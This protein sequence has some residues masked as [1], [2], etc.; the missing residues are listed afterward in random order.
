MKTRRASK[1]AEVVAAVRAAH[2]LYDTPIIFRDPYAI[3][4][5]SRTWRILA[6]HR[7]AYRF[8]AE[9]LLKVLRP[10][11]GQI[12]GRARYCDEL[13]DAAMQHGMKQCVIVGAG[14]DS[15]A[16]RRRDL[17]DI[18]SI[19]E[20]DHPASQAV[21]RQRL[22]SVAEQPPQNLV[23]VPVD[24]EHSTV[25]QALRSTSFQMQEPAFFSWL[26]TTLYLSADAI[27]ATLGDIAAHAAA[28]SELLL[29]YSLSDHLL[30]GTDRAELDA[31]K[32]FVARRGEPF[33]ANFS[34]DEL[35]AK[36]TALG[37]RVIGNLSYQDQWARYFANRHDDLRPAAFSNFL[38]LAVT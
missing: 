25:M 9:R 31:L 30:T 16:L 20:L 26:G 27:F 18:L 33:R 8:V 23:F 13:L 6:R 32:K 29:D 2:L 5:T 7:L 28:G 15:L 38:H 22:V 21:K 24:F 12:L 35:R 36:V 34:P 10:V 4:L 19:Y 3:D 11:R 14:L 1:T 17:A 37:Y